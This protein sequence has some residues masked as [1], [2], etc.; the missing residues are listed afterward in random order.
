MPQ[1]SI[2][3]LPQLTE[4]KTLLIF[5]SFFSPSLSRTKPHSAAQNKLC[6][7]KKM[8]KFNHQSAYSKLTCTFTIKVQITSQKSTNSS[9]ISSTIL[10]IKNIETRHLAKLSRIHTS[11]H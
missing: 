10:R 5:L 1:Y 9:V 2:F 11:Q 4:I 3:A 7:I 6:S 8:D